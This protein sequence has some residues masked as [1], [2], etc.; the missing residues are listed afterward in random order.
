MWQFVFSLWPGGRTEGQTDRRTDGRSHQLHFSVSSSPDHLHF[1]KVFELHLQLPELIHHL[2]VCGTRRHVTAAT[3]TSIAIM[4]AFLKARL[5]G[6]GAY[7]TYIGS[8]R[9]RCFCSCAG[10]DSSDRGPR[11]PWNPER[12]K[13]TRLI[14]LLNKQRPCAN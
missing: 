9:H 2:F 3:Q 13:Q 11:R 5:G 10:W 12:H 8:G 7:C 4:P 14:V 6:V 1:L